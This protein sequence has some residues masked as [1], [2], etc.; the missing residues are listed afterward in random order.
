MTPEERA[1]EL[2]DKWQS[3]YA[4]TGSPLFHL[5]EVQLIAALH[6]QAA[7][8]REACARVVARWAAAAI[9]ART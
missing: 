9:R 7:D 1:R 2:R 4:K 8:E 5:M 6:A 3:T